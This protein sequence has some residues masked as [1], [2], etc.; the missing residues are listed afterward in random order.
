MKI[1]SFIILMAVAVWLPLAGWAQITNALPGRS[2]VKLLPDYARPLVYALNEANGTGPGT[3]L[4]L[5]A[6]NGAVMNEIAVN[7]NPTDMAMSLAG[8]ALYVINN[9]SRTISKIDLTSFTVVAE[10]PITT[11]NTVNINFP[12]HLAAGRSNLVY[13]TDGAWAPSITIFDYANGTNVA[14]YD[15]G[16]GAGGLAVSANGKILYR[17]RQS[18]WYYGDWNSLLTRYD[19]FTNANLTPLEDSAPFGIGQPGNTQV[20]LDTGGCRV[21]SEQGMFAATNVAVQFNEFTDD[22]CGISADGRL[23]FGSA[24]IF[25]SQ[26]TA[27]LTNLPFATTVL[28]VSGDQRNLFLYN[29]AATNL[30]VYDLRGILSLNGSKPVPTPANGSA[31]SVPLTNLV[32]SASSVAL[33]FD[34]YFGTNQA[35][36]AGAVPGSAQYLGRALAPVWPLAGALTPGNNY[37]WRVDQ[38]GFAATNFLM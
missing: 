8:D 29:P 12:L 6:T 5:N 28:T 38:L 19:A 20:F 9:G 3:V 10:K 14:I 21:F 32:W 36:V 1:F 26:S 33:C 37:F 16:N 34:V 27:P 35:Q 18:G 17:C 2:V 13:F 22:I 24:E 11:P 15:D 31:I 30:T 4:A 23:A 25:N 7:L